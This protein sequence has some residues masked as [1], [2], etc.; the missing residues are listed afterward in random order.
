M[1]TYRVARFY[2]ISPGEVDNWYNRD[3]LD[4]AEFMFI[5]EEID[6]QYQVHMD[7]AGGK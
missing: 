6:R 2:Q 1:L 5:Q 7:K 3:F 4:R